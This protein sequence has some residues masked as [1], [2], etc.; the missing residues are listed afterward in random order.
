MIKYI[1]AMN[2]I[3]STNDGFIPSPLRDIMSGPY[4]E[5]IH[6]TLY[7]VGASPYSVLYVEPRYV[8]DAESL[9]K[10]YKRYDGKTN[11]LLPYAALKATPMKTIERSQ[12]KDAL[13]KTPRIKEVIEKSVECTECNGWG[14]VEWTYG[15][16]T[17]DDDCPVCNG[18]G[19]GLSKKVETGKMIFTFEYV[20]KIGN[21]Y[22]YPDRL[23][24]LLNVSETIDAHPQLLYQDESYEYKYTVFKIENAFFV[25]AP[26]KYDQETIVHSF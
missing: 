24:D 20:V 13:D 21:H 26:A 7:M 4:I 17:D 5:A 3:V 6:G 9:C 2:N 12:I 15:A 19:E 16:Y 1:Q 22:F 23:E 18:T 8:G 14:E 10:I 25:L 11:H